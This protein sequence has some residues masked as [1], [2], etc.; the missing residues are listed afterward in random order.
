[1]AINQFDAVINACRYLLINSPAAEESRDYLN[2]RLGENAQ[3]Q[4]SFGYFPNANN[5]KLLTSFVSEKVL[6]K[7]SLFYSKQIA[8]ADGAASF[9]FGFFEQHPLIMPYR[10]VYGTIIGLVGRSLLSD[11]ERKEAGIAKY[12]NTPFTKGNHIFGLYE[13]KEHI[14]KAGFVYVVE[15]Q[16]DVI[17]SFEKGLKNIVALGSANMSAY[18]LAL[19]C[20]YTKN[21]LLM[22]DNDEAGDKGKQLAMNKYSIYA[23]IQD[24]SLPFPYKDIDEFLRENSAEELSFL[25]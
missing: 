25:I 23:N 19:L 10:D 4:F 9:S 6:A 20:R 21:I 8:D 15:G 24:I 12:K 17:K 13:A 7:L 18:Q 14:L 11:S 22:L 1:M 16:F 5:L 2:N 3:Q